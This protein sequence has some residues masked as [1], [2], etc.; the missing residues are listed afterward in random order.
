[1]FPPLLC[2]SICHKCSQKQL[3]NLKTKL[4]P[5]YFIDYHSDNVSFC[6]N[7]IQGYKQI[8]H[9][10]KHLK[11]KFSNWKDASND[12]S[13]RNNMLPVHSKLSISCLLEDRYDGR[14]K[15]EQRDYRIL[16]YFLSEARTKQKWE[17]C[18]ILWKLSIQ[19]KFQCSKFPFSKLSAMILHNE[20]CNVIQ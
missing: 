18:P 14:P 17:K 1:M 19:V 15:H 4:I 8:S 11:D 3:E 2:H 12:I 7:L 6:F 20:I 13:L 10:H 9:K 16:Q 5:T